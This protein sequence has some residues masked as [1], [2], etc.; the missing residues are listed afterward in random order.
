MRQ[1][2]ERK[3]REDEKGLTTQSVRR[4]DSEVEN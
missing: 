4:R 2:A 1:D 3:G